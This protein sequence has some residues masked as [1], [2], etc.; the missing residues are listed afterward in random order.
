MALTKKQ[1]EVFDFIESYSH[2]H[3]YAPTQ[4]EIKDHFGF[5]SFGSVQRYIKYLVNAGL[6]ICDLNARRGLK[7]AYSE[8]KERE[9]P[10][11]GDVAAGNPIEA[12]ENPEPLT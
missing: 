9:I 11:L 3:G 10:L 8:S 1:K 6:L 5:K 12:I 2:T 7:V 4:Q